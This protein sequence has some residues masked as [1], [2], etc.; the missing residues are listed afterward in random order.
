MHKLFT[1]ED[2]PGGGYT[3]GSNQARWVCKVT[4]SQVLH[5]TSEEKP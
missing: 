4:A 3:R 1:R 5:Q 2:F